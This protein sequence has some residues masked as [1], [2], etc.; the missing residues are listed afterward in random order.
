MN[1]V[2]PGISLNARHLSRMDAINSDINATFQIAVGMYDVDDPL[3][4]RGIHVRFL[5]IAT[6]V[7]DYIVLL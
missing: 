3:I 4:L 1:E 5:N 6:E 7:H 2:L